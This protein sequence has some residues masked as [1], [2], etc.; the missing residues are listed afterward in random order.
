MNRIK[1]ERFIK[2]FTENTTTRGKPQPRPWDHMII[3]A[4]KG[5]EK[6]KETK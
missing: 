6:S 1:F 4:P 5:K 2:R 3:T